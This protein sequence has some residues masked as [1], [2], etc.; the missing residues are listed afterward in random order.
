VK[1]AAF[2]AEVAELAVCN[3]VFV[4][5]MGVNLALAREYGRAAPGVRVVEATPSARGENLSVIGALGLTGM[6]AMMSVPGA[7]DGAA[8]QVFIEEVLVPQLRAGEIVLMDNVP[9]HKMAV[10]EQ[11]IKSVGAR[12]LFLPPYSPD[13]SPIENCWSKI[14][15]ILRGIGARTRTELEEALTKALAM[16]TLD[17]V[18]GWFAH[19]GYVDALN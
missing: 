2:R 12:V 18:V 3:F 10:L 16:L 13:C 15:T 9:T 4:D 11:A 1:R 8:C 14:K 5:E 7:V 6:R 17:D 19:C